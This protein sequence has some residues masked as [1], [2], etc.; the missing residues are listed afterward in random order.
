MDAYNLTFPSSYEFCSKYE[1]LLQ[2]CQTALD[3]WANRREEAHQ[4]GLSGKELGDEL[5][6]LQAHFAKSYAILRNH[7]HECPCC[8]FVATGGNIPADGP[9]VTASHQ[10]QPV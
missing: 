4:L 2:V 7:T 8:L 5:V 6:R 10:T 9:A 3:A 1:E